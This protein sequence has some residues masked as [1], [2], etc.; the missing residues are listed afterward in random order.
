M[1]SRPSYGYVVVMPPI[2]VVIRRLKAS[3]VR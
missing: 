3:R 1:A 2:V